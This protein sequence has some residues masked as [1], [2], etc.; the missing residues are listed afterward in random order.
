MNASL[1]KPTRI[2]REFLVACFCAEW[3]GTC[4]EYKEGFDTLQ[5]AFPH[6]DFLWFDVEDAPEWSENFDVE[7]FPTILIQ[8]N[9]L[10]LFYGAMLPHHSQLQRMIANF[11]S[12][13]LEEAFRFANQTLE[14]KDWQKNKNLRGYLKQSL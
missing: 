13:S 2:E 4:R 5:A 8:R 9:N 1:S 12:Q 14:R 7:N 10:V 11:E 6:I 3:C